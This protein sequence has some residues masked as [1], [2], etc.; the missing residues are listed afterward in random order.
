MNTSIFDTPLDKK[1]LRDIMGWNPS[2]LKS[3]MRLIEEELQ[4]RFG[5]KYNKYK[6]YFH[7]DVFF[8]VLDYFG[9]DNIEDINAR[10]KAIKEAL[11]NQKVKNKSF[12]G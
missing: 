3:E 12:I 7:R 4:E 2:K 9:Y 1:L 11:D 6:S 8:H 5:N 10:I